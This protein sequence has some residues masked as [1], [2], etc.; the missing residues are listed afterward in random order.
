M[1]VV[2]GIDGGGTKT[3]CLVADA[4]GRILG[5][6]M[7]G[8]SNYHAIGVEAAAGNVRAAA[9]AALAAAGSGMAAVAAVCAGLA[10]VG[11][12]EDQQMM[13]QALSCFAPA[14][15]SVVSDGRVALAGA[16]GGQPGVI[17]I[18]G[19]GSIAFGL[20]SAGQ[21]HRAGGW[22]WI[23]GDEGSGVTIGRQALMAALA[24]LDGTGPATALTGRVCAAW[25]LERPDQAIR[26]IYADLPR[27]KAD[28]AALAPLVI[29]AE[30]A[31][32]G[33]ARE[34][35]TRAG[36]DLAALAAA[37]LRR[38]ALPAGSPAPVAITGGVGSASAVLRAAL[39]EK[40]TDL[41]PQAR[42]IDPVEEPAAGAVRLALELL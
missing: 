26:Q 3:C 11:R 6:G 32:D 1:Q 18:A 27:A 38:L 39:R 8:P 28:F 19:T 4:A 14:R 25:R 5:Q 20:D 37:V 21:T 2:L 40:L 34:I 23:L 35:L 36:H 30:A 9:E 10:G 33:V 22:G 42:L 7:A 15:L 29:A 41:A 17:L 12:P 16:L 31:G 24:E 13:A